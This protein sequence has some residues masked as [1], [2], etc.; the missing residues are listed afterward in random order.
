[1]IDAHTHLNSPALFP[2]WKQHILDFEKNWGTCLVNTWA[3]DEYNQ[4]GLIISKEYDGK[5]F[6]KCTIWYSPHEVLAN[7]ISDNN[8]ENKVEELKK[9]YLENKDHIVAIWE[10]WIDTHF[11]EWSSLVL[12]KSL[13]KMQCKLAKELSLPVVVH[14]RD[15]FD[16]TMEV[17]K[18]FKGLK[19][20]FHCR[21]YGP[22]EI[23]KLKDCK[24]KYYWIGFCGNITYPKADN[25]RESLLACNMENILIETDAPYLPPQNLRWETNYPTNIKYTYEF[26]SKELWINLNNITIQIQKNFNRLFLI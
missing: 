24:L 18:E 26:I 7:K 6:V 13:F 2:N 11:D 12:Q 19:I 10:I 23:K 1:M 15:D 4:N 14:S 25:I 22:D 17:L 3:D 8:I 21:G 20:Y 9:L 5:I 16:A